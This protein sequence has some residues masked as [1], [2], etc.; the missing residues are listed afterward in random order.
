MD[1]WD[2]T[3]MKYSTR[4][5]I[6]VREKWDLAGSTPS[7]CRFS[8][9]ITNVSSRERA[10]DLTARI[11]SITEELD[12]GTSNHVEIKH[13]DSDIQSLLS[14]TLQAGLLPRE[15]EREK[16]ASFNRPR[17]SPRADDVTRATLYAW[18]ASRRDRYAKLGLQLTDNIRR[19]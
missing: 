14:W 13:D 5:S 6:M 11:I 12:R 1:T 9:E 8:I 19:K 4:I 16:A 2:W 17:L 18:S 10:R 3:E 7:K 15:R